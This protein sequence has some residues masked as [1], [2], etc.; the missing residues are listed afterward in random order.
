MCIG[1]TLCGVHVQWYDIHIELLSSTNW[2]LFYS[3][4]YWISIFF[5][6]LFE[7]QFS[8]WWNVSFTLQKSIYYDYYYF[9]SARLKF[10]GEKAQAWKKNYWNAFVKH[11]HTQ[12]TSSIAHTIHIVVCIGV[13]QCVCVYLCVLLGA[14]RMKF[15]KCLQNMFQ[16]MKAA[17]GWKVVGTVQ[18]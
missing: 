1:N 18:T 13:C 11:M 16:I 15:G 5:A 9:C 12:H 14:K 4:I 7:I 8:R 3:K 17:K 10:D 6:L 2:Y